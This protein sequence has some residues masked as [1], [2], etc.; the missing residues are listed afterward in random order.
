ME[1]KIQEKIDRVLDRIQDPQTG[2]A[3]SQLGLVEK[4]RY[5]EKRRKLIVFFNC[6]GHSKACCAALNMVLLGDFETEIKAGLEAEFP[7]FSVTFTDF[8]NT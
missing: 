2:M 4:I 7:Q 8:S 1:D 5:V 3:M 6:L